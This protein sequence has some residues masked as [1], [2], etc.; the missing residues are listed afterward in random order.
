MDNILNNF[1][2]GDKFA[3]LGEG[4]RM[5]ETIAKNTASLVEPNVKYFLKSTLQKC[6]S[7]K[8]KNINLFFNLGLGSAFFIIV[9]IILYFKYRGNR[10]YREE[11][12]KRRKDKEYIIKKLIQIKQQNNNDRMMRTNMITDLPVFKDTHPELAT[13]DVKPDTDLSHTVNIYNPFDHI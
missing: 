13:L 4:T 7:I 8:E 11:Q 9:G 2:L 12:I 6:N 3:S 1:G 10:S 5:T